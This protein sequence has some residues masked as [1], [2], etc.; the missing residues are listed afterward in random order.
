MNSQPEPSAV[1]ISLLPRTPSPP[2]LTDT[3]WAPGKHDPEDKALTLIPIPHLTRDLSNYNQ[4]LHALWFHIVY[5]RLVGFILPRNEGPV[6]YRE[7][8]EA[9]DQHNWDRRHLH[10][11][12]IV[13]SSIGREVLEDM[14]LD[15]GLRFDPFDDRDYW[16]HELMHKV[17][18]Y[19]ELLE[20]RMRESSDES[21]ESQRDVV[22]P[23][24]DEFLAELRI[25]AS[26]NGVFN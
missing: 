18:V 12:A 25:W 11:Y 23:V 4:W 2:G 13:F 24:E 19:K 8:P 20:E 26:I 10:T 6:R 16:A 15:R 14:A 1:P 3:S 22:P 5:H 7:C 21:D 17:E 9:E